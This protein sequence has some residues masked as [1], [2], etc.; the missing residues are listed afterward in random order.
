MRE[1]CLE[2]EQRFSVG[3]LAGEEGRWAN[4]RGMSLLSRDRSYGS[5]WSPPTELVTSWGSMDIYPLG[6]V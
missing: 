1:G 6:V 5:A 2:E 4:Y 3:G